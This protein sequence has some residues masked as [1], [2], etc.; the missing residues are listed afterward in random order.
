MRYEYIPSA[1][2]GGQLRLIDATDAEIVWVMRTPGV[3]HRPGDRDIEWTEERVASAM[4]LARTEELFGKRKDERPWKRSDIFF[5]IPGFKSEREALALLHRSGVVIE[6][7]RPAI[8][9]PVRR[10]ST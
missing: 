8:R 9:L 10:R 3:P 4:S 6:R 2:G 7:P 5:Q 1:F